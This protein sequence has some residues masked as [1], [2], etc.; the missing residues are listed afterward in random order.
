MIY[1]DLNENE[2]VKYA[3]IYETIRLI[4]ESAVHR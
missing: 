4:T 3:S 2:L 1:C